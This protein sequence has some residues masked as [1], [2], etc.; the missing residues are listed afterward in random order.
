VLAAAARLRRREDFAATVRRGRRAA[1]G[2][3]I[4][5]VRTNPEAPS[6][7]VQAGFIV[8]R[9]VGGAVVRNAVRR[10]LRHAI[11]P[12]LAAFPAG[13]AIVVRTLPAAATRSYHD[14]DAD[15][16][17]ALAAALPVAVRPGATP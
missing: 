12:R 16:A 8:S 1:R 9:A 5:H 13:T 3:L 7:V 14:L 11:R 15:L 17:A 4:V 10:R 6:S 2:A